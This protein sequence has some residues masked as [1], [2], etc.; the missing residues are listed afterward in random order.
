MA[1][2]SDSTRRAK[3]L[4][5]T[6]VEIQADATSQLERDA[7]IE[8]AFEAVARVHRLMS[9]HDPESDVSRLNREARTRP[10]KVDPWTFQVLEAAVEMHRRSG[11]VFDVAVAPSLQ[12]LLSD[13]AVS[14][15]SADVMIDLGGIAKGFAVDR[16]VEAMR[17]LNVEGGLVNAGGDLRAFGQG[18]HT[19][20]I[21][22]PRDPRRT[23]CQVDIADEAL[24]STALRF[25]LFDSADTIG[26]AVIDPATRKQPAGFDG[27]T[28]RAGSCMIADALTKVVMIDG[29]GAEALLEHY[30]AGAL[31][32]SRDGE[33]LISPDWHRAVHRAA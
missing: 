7:A 31:L 11:G 33:I 15:R 2:A 30:G 27:V 8:A 21:R 9:F 17:G 23:I 12:A 22:N 20:H 25:D 18:S 28:I 16:A 3:P 5:G 13:N 19:V 26:S 24:A 14:F 4:L 29:T 10:T 32:V 1:T 6:F